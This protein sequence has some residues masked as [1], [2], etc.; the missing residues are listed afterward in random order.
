MLDSRTVSRLSFLL[1]VV[2]A[3]CADRPAPTTASAAAS[4]AVVSAAERTISAIQGA[5][6]RSP[7]E[8]ARVQTSGVVTAVTDGG[9][10][11]WIQDPEGDGDAA[12][13][14]G[15]FVAL[16]PVSVAVGEVVTVTGSV[17]ERG[18]DRD[19]P[20]TTLVAEAVTRDGTAE[21]PAP[22]G[23][24]GR[25]RAIPSVVI[26]DDGLRRFDPNTDGIDY[27][28]SL[29]GMRVAVH[30]VRIVGPTSRFGD[31]VGVA[32]GG[33]HASVST[34]RGGLLQR[35]GDANPER[36]V[37]D[38][39]ITGELPTVDVGAHF[40]STVEAIVGYAF[41]HYRLHVT[42]VPTV[43]PRAPLARE[44]TALC[45][46]E[47][48]TS[49]A[50]FNVLNLAATDPAEKF[51][52]LAEVLVDGL[53]APDLVG[54]QEVQDDDGAVG[55]DLDVAD[56]TATVT[57]EATWARLVDAVVEAGGP[58]YAWSQID[59]VHRA[60]G[61]RPGGNIRVG[62]LYRPDRF[63]VTTVERIE[64]AAF[65][66]DPE[67]G[68]G[69]SRKPLA[70]R[71]ESAAG[72]ELLLV[73]VHLSSKGGDDR[74]MGA[75]QPPVRWSEVRR[76]AQAHAVRAYVDRVRAAEPT[77]EAIVLGDFNEHL[78]RAPS[79]VIAGGDWIQLLARLPSDERYTYVYLGQSQVLDQI[80]VTPGLAD[81]AEIDV[82]HCCA[83]F[84]DSNRASDHDPVVVRLRLE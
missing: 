30:D 47:G 76:T 16:E 79:H 77:L 74:A 40:E 14:D 61:G 3:G 75:R 39:R 71:V 27:F 78:D 15:L 6:H 41:G 66:A 45:G 31:A 9:D 11:F 35:E 20:V 7:H 34:P 1:L 60:D 24:G 84:A 8:G 80:V 13:S 12:T 5:D 58:R 81:G 54:V 59:P 67:S 50:A 68:R 10:G 29:E 52:A 56:P 36:L 26:D 4:S 43:A 37:F 33:R 63:T 23:L 83:E 70:V 22:I 44:A 38:P 51:A 32:D 21:L 73:V 18:R 72:R 2:L 42:A 64:G 69:G 82:V 55:G 53:G 19:L 57:A 48:W 46:G 65:D 28:E 17:E 25:G 62:L 49:V